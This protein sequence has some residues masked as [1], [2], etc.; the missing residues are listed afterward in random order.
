MKAALHLI[1]M[2]MLGFNSQQYLCILTN[3]IFGW[4]FIRAG[5][6]K[7]F[8]WRHSFE[9][10]SSEHETILKKRQALSS[11]FNSGKISQSTFELFD[12]E[13]EEAL[14][15][16]EKQKR[17]LLERMA[18]KVREVEEQ[19]R[20]LEKLLANYEIQHVS[21]EVDEETYQ[22]EIALLSIGLENARR[23][24]NAIKETMDKL[25]GANIPKK[26]EPVV[27]QTTEIKTAEVLEVGGVEASAELKTE[28]Q[29]MAGDV[30]VSETSK[31][32]TPAGEEAEK[33]NVESSG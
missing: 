3:V 31:V 24:L 14:A 11:L 6:V 32:E 25:V 33:G 15:E 7:L 8:S 2:K 10:I 22:R 13:I 19:I 29:T 12:R 20:I 5:V 23:E 16:V 21:G 9:R 26:V 17:V 30:N 4:W 1:A 28:T 18:S 27:Q